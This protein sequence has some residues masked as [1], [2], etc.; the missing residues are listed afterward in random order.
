MKTYSDRSAVHQPL[1]NMGA[2]VVLN[3]KSSPSLIF[4]KQYPTILLQSLLNFIAQLNNNNAANVARYNELLPLF[5]NR[6]VLAYVTAIGM[7]GINANV[8]NNWFAKL[9]LKFLLSL[10]RWEPTIRH[11]AP[12][13]ILKVSFKLLN[14]LCQDMINDII[15]VFDNI[16]FSTN[17]YQHLD[18]NGVEEFKKYRNIYAGYFLAP[19]IKSQVRAEVEVWEFLGGTNNQCF[20]AECDQKLCYVRLDNFENLQAPDAQNKG[21]FPS[22]VTSKKSIIISLK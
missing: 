17:Y 22:N 14:C 18:E 12:T 11:I 5:F 9:E 20:V 16:V 19:L 21:R 13:T 10:I 7:D 2:V 1:P 3:I 8:K 4:V 6:H 15:F